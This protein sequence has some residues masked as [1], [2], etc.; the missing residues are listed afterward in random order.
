MR[1]AAAVQEMMTRPEAKT[2]GSFGTEFLGDKA[3][4]AKSFCNISALIAD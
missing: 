3:Y 1:K 2:K 4:P